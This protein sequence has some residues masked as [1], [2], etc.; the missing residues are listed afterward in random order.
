MGMSC[1]PKMASID[2]SAFN[3]KTLELFAYSNRQFECYNIRNGSS[4]VL[5]TGNK[6]KFGHFPQ[7]WI[8]PLPEN[9][10][11][12]H[13]TGGSKSK[14]DKI[15]ST[16][17]KAFVHTK[18]LGDSKE[19]FCGASLV[20]VRGGAYL[21]GGMDRR[22]RPFADIWRYSLKDQIWN[23]V[24]LKLPHSM[25]GAV[26]VS[27]QDS[28]K[29]VIFEIFGNRNIF[30][31]D[32]KKKSVYQSAVLLPQMMHV[33]ERRFTAINLYDEHREQLATF[34]FSRNCFEGGRYYG[35]YGYELPRYLIK[36][37][38]KFMSMETVHLFS[39]ST[40]E[41]FQVNLDVLLEA[42]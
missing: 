40:G 6:C 19:V 11:F 41:H 38:G 20:R 37:A 4:V 23:E 31:Y 29:I 32:I 8:E 27:S 21:L 14:H 26:S 3:Q 12:V 5:L 34:G 28:T 42:K 1:S 16:E 24:S 30:V 15:W 25:S 18:K 22:C 35:V 36:F 39:Q 33:N 7:V 9:K 13:I 17:K 10:S 2:A